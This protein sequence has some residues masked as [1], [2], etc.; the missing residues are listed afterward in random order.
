MLIFL[1]SLI[2]LRCSKIETNSPT[3]D[4]LGKD[5]I[6]LY[7]EEQMFFQKFVGI[8]NNKQ[9]LILLTDNSAG[10]IIYDTNT[11]KVKNYFGIAGNDQNYP[12]ELHNPVHLTIYKNHI[13][14]ADRGDNT[15]KRFDY[16]GN[17]IN[18]FKINFS[19]AF[20]ETFDEKLIIT[21]LTNYG[22]KGLH[23]Y[24]LWGNL[25]ED[26]ISLPNRFNNFN[27]VVVPVITANK[28]NLVYAYR[29][30][31]NG[32][33]IFNKNFEILENTIESINIASP[34]IFG[35][36]IGLLY[37][38]N[39]I[40]FLENKICIL[41]G[42]GFPQSFVETQKN[43]LELRYYKESNRYYNLFS[44]LDVRNKQ[45]SRFTIINDNFYFINNSEPVIYSYKLIE[46]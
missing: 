33:E 19:P 41:Y 42:G 3:L 7:N 36:T 10:C 28:D 37:S 12:A 39:Y 31:Y 46:E 35:K 27:L 9:D 20:I 2:I 32:Y 45:F 14:I 40:E 26:K 16:D 44:N 24:D 4:Y 1:L 6:F 5:S 8:D 22:E 25:I 13:F 43:Y 21:P 15:I 17:F 38:N 18:S 34:K 11:K 29:C 30:G 23:I